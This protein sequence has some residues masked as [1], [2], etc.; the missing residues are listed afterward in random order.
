ME[1]EAFLVCD[2]ATDQ[3]GKLNVLG[4]F[5]VIFAEKMPITL[6]TC[7]ITTRIRFEKIEDGDH[8]VKI[9]IINKDGKNIGPKPEGRVSVKTGPGSDS[10][11]ANLILNIQGLKFEQYGIYRIDLAIDGNI[12]A[13]LPLRV[14]EPSSHE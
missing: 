6:P 13:S 5:D 14:A 7:S 9:H 11:V 2:A 10:T 12:K 1:I 3:Q 4:A 8:S